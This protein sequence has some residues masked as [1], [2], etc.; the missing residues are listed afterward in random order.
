MKCRDL[1]FA[2]II[3][4]VF[5]M[6]LAGCG[7][8][9]SKFYL[10]HPM[11]ASEE[12][13]STTPETEGPSILIGPITL[14]AYLN[15]NQ[16]VVLDGDHEVKMKELKRWAEPLEDNF[17]RVLVE[18]L[19]LLLNTTKVYAFNSR[20]TT[21]ADFQII[22]DVTRFDSVAGGDA[23]LN[24]FWTVTGKNGGTYLMERKS[25]FIAV[26]SSIG[27]EG[28]VDAQNRTLNEFSREVATAIQSLL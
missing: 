22:I 6:L 11:T 5:V 23:T 21:P 20:D 12:G 15:R 24:A 13:V 27:L 9:P 3:L 14:P 7:G 1:Y 4:S 19:S 16:I 2:S 28:V 8:R 17:Y 25:V 26:A 10:L 18:N